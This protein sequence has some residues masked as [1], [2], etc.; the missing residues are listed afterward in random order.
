M[1]TNI[2]NEALNVLT[3]DDK[4]QVPHT[5]ADR[6]GRLL[7]SDTQML[8]ELRILNGAMAMQTDD[9]GTGTTYQAWAEP[10]T[11][12]SAAS[13]RIKRIVETAGDYSITF[14]DGNRNFDNV[15]DDR[16]IL[17]YS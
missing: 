2:Q 5:A 15:W 16:L 10:G 11:A 9:L 14:A 13:W 6:F 8:V 1:P 12:T 7:I 17:S 3:P 4:R